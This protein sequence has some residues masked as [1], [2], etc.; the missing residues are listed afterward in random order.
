MSKQLLLFD[1]SQKVTERKKQL[2]EL[3][4][5]LETCESW[6][7]FLSMRIVLLS[8]SLNDLQILELLEDYKTF[9]SPGKDIF[10]PVRNYDITEKQILEFYY[11]NCD[12]IDGLDPVGKDFLYI[13]LC[14]VI[15]LEG[16]NKRSLKESIRKVITDDTT[17]MNALIRIEALS[18]FMLS[19]GVPMRHRVT[20]PG[21]RPW[22]LFSNP[23]VRS[24][25]FEIKGYPIDWIIDTANFSRMLRDI[26]VRMEEGIQ[27]FG[28]IAD[29]VK[30]DDYG[31]RDEFKTLSGSIRAVT[32]IMPFHFAL[33][34]EL[35][36]NDPKRSHRQ[37]DLRTIA[38][39]LGVS[40][41][42]LL[43]FL[44]VGEGVEMLNI[45]TVTA[46]ILKSIVA[47]IETAN[48]E[49]LS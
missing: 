2:Q 39:E 41:G 13:F 31:L 8:S 30:G 9:R 28:E 3:T 40:Y 16:E 33:E 26:S 36:L 42:V 47:E 17:K 20:Y 5:D 25:Q 4:R 19:R 14:K 7:P 46:Q 35:L 1:E 6:D 23:T 43:F 15:L 49:P 44:R 32:G 12:I 45:T 34:R 10:L 18:D 29:S 22:M 48:K 27:D 38:D 11:L 21:E 24:I 37:P